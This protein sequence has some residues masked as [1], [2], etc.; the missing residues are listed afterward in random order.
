M[1]EVMDKLKTLQENMLTIYKIIENTK[2]DKLENMYRINQLQLEI[3]KLVHDINNQKTELN[4][5]ISAAETMVKN[6]IS[7]QF[8]I[9]A[10]F[11]KKLKNIERRQH[12]FM[13]EYMQQTE[14]N[15]DDTIF[16]NINPQQMSQSTSQAAQNAQRSSHSTQPAFN[17]LAAIFGALSKMQDVGL[18]TPHDKTHEKDVD[19]D[20]LSEVSEY[21][22]SDEIEELNTNIKTIDDLIELG[23]TYP[24]LMEADKKKQR[25]QKRRTRR[26]LN[27]SAPRGAPSGAIERAPINNSSEQDY[28]ETEKK[29]NLFKIGDKLYPLNLELLY[30][31]TKP[32]Q[33]LNLM[34][35]LQNIK[36]SLIDMII[37]YLQRF[38]KK[39]DT[40]LHTIIEGGPG[41]GKTELGRIIGNIYACLGVTKTNNFKIVRR[42][43][44]IGEYVGHTAHKTQQAIDEADGGV[45]FID[46]AY[47]LGTSDKIDSFSQECINT[48]NQNLSE[49]RSKIVC[50]IA[51]YHDELESSFFAYNPGLRRRFPFKYV[52]NEYSTSELKNIFIKKISDINWK[53]NET[54]M[55]VNIF[56]NISNFKNYGGDIENLITEC[57]FSHSK[58]ILGKHPKYRRILTNEDITN[59]YKRFMEHKK[60]T[61]KLSI[62]HIYL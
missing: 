53:F 46:E 9:L 7:Q 29:S 51:G 3:T 48:L 15:E 11:G 25:N 27:H 36:E 33:K 4:D 47:S 42:T 49:N 58:R 59:G 45:L 17:P 10:N 21:S 6:N 57:K 2:T 50:I 44:L 23:N 19:D 34:I 30:K 35:G 24:K 52:I 56:D 26:K 14:E 41:V 22:S 40:M 60:D 54:A 20:K 43:D 39:N 38:E 62:A 61:N 13:H 8:K 16:I 28:Y 18:E 31:L 12:K 1:T 5:R 55:N 37:Y 32:L